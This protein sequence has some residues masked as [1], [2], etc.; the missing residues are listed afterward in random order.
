MQNKNDWRASVV[1]PAD[2]AEKIYQ[3]RSREGLARCSLSDIIRKLIATG[4]STLEV[5]GGSR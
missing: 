5:D 2:L 3:L 1:I 4:L